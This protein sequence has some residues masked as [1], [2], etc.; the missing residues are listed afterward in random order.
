MELYID[1]VCKKP[2]GKSPVREPSFVLEID[3]HTVTF[4]KP[5]FLKH[6]VN[7]EEWY[8][9]EFKNNDIMIRFTSFR[10]KAIPIVYARNFQYI[11]GSITIDG[12]RM[13]NLKHVSVYI[14][15][16][17]TI[18]R[19][20]NRTFHD[21]YAGVSLFDGYL[22]SRGS[23]RTVHIYPV[24]GESVA[25]LAKR[26]FGT[27]YDLTPEYEYIQA[28]VEQKKELLTKVGG[29][30]PAE[31]SYSQ[32][33]ELCQ[34]LGVKQPVDP[35]Q[36]CIYTYLYYDHGVGGYSSL[37]AIEQISVDL[38]HALGKYNYKLREEHKRLAKAK[39]DMILEESPPKMNGQLWEGCE[40]CGREPV[41]LPLHLCEKCWP[42][43]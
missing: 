35:T 12:L 25:S 38:I 29:S 6:D 5:W 7:V 4:E 15:G 33:I 32:Y 43:S 11:Y 18:D 20:G 21:Y 30:L 36:D 40:I 22:Y 13:A 17:T 3:G 8:A 39:Q 41:Y 23:G 1:P 37:S 42:T 27:D 10:G 24:E 14:Y 2:D 16:I 31:I 9:N 19:S 34:I 26:V 28:R